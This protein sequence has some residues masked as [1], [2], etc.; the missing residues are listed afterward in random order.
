LI[1]HDAEFLT[2]HART[3][4]E[5]L[6]KF[7]DLGVGFRIAQHDL[8]LRG[9]GDLLGK[10]QHGHIAAVGYDMY[11]D[12]LKEAVGELK[13]QEEIEEIEP[14]VIL[15]MS[16]MI[17]EKYCPDLHE[18]MAFYQRIASANSDD[19]LKAILYD[20]EDLYGDAPK[21]VVALINS[22]LIKL[23][24][25]NIFALKLEM[26]K[27]KDETSLVVSISLSERSPVAHDKII[28][29]QKSTSSLRI[30]PQQKVI[31]IIDQ[32][33][34]SSPDAALFAA[35]EAIGNLKREILTDSSVR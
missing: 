8:E 19:K 1:K 24:L 30:T 9:A 27:G 3:R 16:A 21:E 31:Q 20:L 10:N 14:E 29:L 18:R 13:G 7:S 6:H 32:K 15:P 26:S 22:A 25:K 5:I 17:S 35:T 12:L 23:K 2:A 34:P 11:A 4:L 33:D 28:A